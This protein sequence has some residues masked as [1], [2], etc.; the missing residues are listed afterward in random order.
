MKIG[1]YLKGERLKKGITIKEMAAGICRS[2]PT[3]TA[4]EHGVSHSRYSI[5]KIIEYL[6]MSFSDLKKYKFDDFDIS[7]PE[8]SDIKDAGF[9]AVFDYISE[10]KQNRTRVKQ[11]INIIEE[12]NDR[13]D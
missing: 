13:G 9:E 12:I 5:N 8:E 11:V 4:I 6:G 7:E 1:E 2:A 3:I 10:S